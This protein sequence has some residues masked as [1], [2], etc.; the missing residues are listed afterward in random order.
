[1]NQRSIVVA[2]CGDLDLGVRDELLWA[3]VPLIEAPVAIIDL[4]AVTFA[5]T[6]FINAVRD[7]T[8]MRAASLRNA[9]R[10]R[11]VGASSIVHRIFAIAHL[12]SLVDFFTSLHEAE[13]EWSPAAF[14]HITLENLAI[15]RTAT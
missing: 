8:R 10:L 3:L 4:T 2:L 14:R 6:T 9:T 11:I 15:G 7:T 12:E 5:D 13:I 1:M